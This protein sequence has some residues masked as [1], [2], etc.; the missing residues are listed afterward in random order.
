MK[1]KLFKYRAI[2]K[3]AID[4][5]IN[6]RLYFSDWRSLNDAHEAQMLVRYPGLM[7][8]GNPDRLKEFNDSAIIVEQCE[9]RVCSLSSSCAGNLL[10]SHYGDSHKGVV[11]GLDLPANLNAQEVEMV[12]VVYDDLIP[13]VPSPIGKTEVM[14]ALEHKSKEWEQEKEVRL[15]KLNPGDSYLNEITIRDVV[16]GLRT[17]EDDIRLIRQII[18]DP[19]IK[20]WKI[21]RKPGHYL[22]NVTD[23]R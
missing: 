7:S 16:F 12:T 2:D 15:I 3:R 9:A 20:F 13:E 6:K 5:L 21:C 18:Q 10:W 14:R 1:S 22:L 17:S 11:I 19:I 4:I 23:M 8:H